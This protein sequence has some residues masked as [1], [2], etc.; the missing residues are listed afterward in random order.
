MV[1]FLIGKYCLGLESQGLAFLLKMP[2]SYLNI[3]SDHGGLPSD[4][5]S[6]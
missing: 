2:E 6:S 4:G 3:C 5:M 1:V